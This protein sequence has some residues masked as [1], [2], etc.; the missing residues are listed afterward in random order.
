MASCLSGLTWF[1]IGC[2][3]M[4]QMRSGLWVV[5]ALLCVAVSI[6]VAI[7]FLER[8]DVSKCVA[9]LLGGLNIYW[10]DV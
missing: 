4:F 8:G 1:F 6:V 2:G 5:W 7:A 9:I 3:V 10:I